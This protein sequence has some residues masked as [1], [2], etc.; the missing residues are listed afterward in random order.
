L[1]S[2]PTGLEAIEAIVA[3]APD[4]LDADGAALV[5]EIAPGQSDA[6]L[7]LARAA[8]F[9]DAHVARDLAGRDRV[10]VARVMGAR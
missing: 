3:G 7:A 2:G 9:D 4:W 5:V 1:V 8:G 10:L 6:V